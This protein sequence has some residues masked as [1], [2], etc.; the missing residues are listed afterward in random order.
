MKGRH[1]STATKTRKCLVNV[2]LN[3]KK[4]YSKHNPSKETGLNRKN[5]FLQKLFPEH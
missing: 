4:G 5:I 2:A 1:D 3:I